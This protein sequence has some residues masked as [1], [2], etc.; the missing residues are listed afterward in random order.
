MH[1]TPFHSIF[2]VSTEK[3]SIPNMNNVVNCI[4]PE[5]KSHSFVDTLHGLS[6]KL[7]QL[8][9]LGGHDDSKSKSGKLNRFVV[10]F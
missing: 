8:S 3:G 4:T 9:H 1:C 7:H 10:C 2:F 6:D 5:P